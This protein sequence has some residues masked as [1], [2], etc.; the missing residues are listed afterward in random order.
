M[1]LMTLFGWR[2]EVYCVTIC[3]CICFVFSLIVF[4]VVESGVVSRLCV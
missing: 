3:V 2:V 4:G 1:S